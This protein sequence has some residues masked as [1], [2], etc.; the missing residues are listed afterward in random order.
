MVLVGVVAVNGSARMGE[1]N[2]ARV[3][4]PFLN[5]MREAGASVELFYAKKLNVK[6]CMGEFHCWYKKPGA[7]YIEDD[8]QMLYPKLREADVLVLAMPVYIPLSGE[9]QNLV[10]RLCP[11]IEPVLSRRRGR[12]RAKFHDDVKIRKIILVSTCAWWEIG[13]FGTV[14]RVAKELA[15]NTRVE[16]AGAVLRPHAQLMTEHKDKAREIMDALRQAGLETVERGR[17][18]KGLLKVIGQPLVSEEE[19]RHSENDD[20]ER[21][22]SREGLEPS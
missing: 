13:N 4:A 16:F 10:N 8:M 20:Y 18:S 15:E 1:G 22:K 5:G 21:A 14:V 3:L 19:F 11:L 6:P 9:M 7:C 12:T 17:I 2:T